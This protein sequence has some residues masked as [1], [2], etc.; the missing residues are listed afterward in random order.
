MPATE[1]MDRVKSPAASAGPA[2]R[3]QDRFQPRRK[4]LYDHRHQGDRTRQVDPRAGMSPCR[5]GVILFS[6]HAVLIGGAALRAPPRP[7]FAPRCSE[8][9]KT[10][11]SYSEVLNH[12]KLKSIDAF[13]LNYNSSKSF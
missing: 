5:R 2:S 3:R 6:N 10:A 4:V 12:Y 1:M 9:P 7:R 11:P 8:H 13:P